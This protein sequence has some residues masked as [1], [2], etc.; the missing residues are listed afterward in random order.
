MTKHTLKIW[1]CSHRMI[2]KY[3]WTFYNFMHKRITV[4][5][6]IFLQWMITDIS[7][8]ILMESFL[9]TTH[10]I[11]TCLVFKR[12]EKFCELRDSLE[13]FLWNNFRILEHPILRFD[14]DPFHL[15]VTFLYLLESSENQSFLRGYSWRD[16]G[17]KM[18]TY[19]C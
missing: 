15:N 10:V 7:I 5:S 12:K 8:T 19:S 1:C 18:Y 16:M 3:V 2:F 9:Y 11:F 13:L 14:I 6:L 4:C 17:L